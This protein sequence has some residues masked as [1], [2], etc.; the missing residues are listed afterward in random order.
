LSSLRATVSVLRSALLRSARTLLLLFLSAV[1]APWLSSTPTATR[2][3]QD[4]LLLGFSHAQLGGY[5]MSIWGLPTA[6]VQA[7][8][9]HHCPSLAIGSEFSSLTAAHCADALVHAAQEGK[10]TPAVD[11]AYLDRL[12]VTGSLT[13]WRNLLDEKRATA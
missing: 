11:K 3:A 7:V 12:G 5:L 13:A 2:H 6:L 10:E 4:L 9:L 1:L 8:A